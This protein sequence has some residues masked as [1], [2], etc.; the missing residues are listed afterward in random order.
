[1]YFHQETLLLVIFV[2]QESHLIIAAGEG[3]VAEINN[4]LGKGVN[5]HCED[6]VRSIY[7]YVSIYSRDRAICKS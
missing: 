1:M 4:L 7:M 5:L 6:E 2:A 3:R